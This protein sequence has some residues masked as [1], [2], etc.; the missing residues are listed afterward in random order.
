[1]E[2]NSYMD[3]VLWL[4]GYE[5]YPLFREDTSSMYRFI[6]KPGR[7]HVTARRIRDLI[8]PYYHSEKDLDSPNLCNLGGIVF[9]FPDTVFPVI[10]DY[11]ISIEELV[12]ILKYETYELYTS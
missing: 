7:A 5:W 2:C 11:F 4:F 8:G 12:K 10:L 6:Y 1:M 3:K 9:A